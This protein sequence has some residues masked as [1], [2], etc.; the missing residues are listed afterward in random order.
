MPSESRHY[1]GRLDTVG[2]A[3]ARAVTRINPE[4]GNQT[5]VLTIRRRE[6]VLT[7]EDYGQLA[8]RCALLAFGC[9]TPGV[10]EELRTLSL[11]YL[12]RAVRWRSLTCRNLEA[13]AV[14]PKV[15]AWPTETYS[16]LSLFALGAPDAGG[17]C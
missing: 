1:S 2:C 12:T 13:S 10:A 14:V 4:I 17:G 7:P 11:D 8:E 16:G 3:I 15:H 6:V 5:T 9:A